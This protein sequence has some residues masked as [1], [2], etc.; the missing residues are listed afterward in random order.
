MLIDFENKASFVDVSGNI[1]Q[2]AAG[3]HDI[4][5]GTGFVRNLFSSIVKASSEDGSI[6]V[7][8][9]LLFFLTKSEILMITLLIEQWIL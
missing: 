3:E 1:K 7:V 5:L 8:F 4:L 9:P 6:V 2:I